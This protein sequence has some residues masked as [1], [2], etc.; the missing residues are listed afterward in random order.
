MVLRCA[1]IGGS[2][3][4]SGPCRVSTWLVTTRLFVSIASG[5]NGLVCWLVGS[6]YCP[7]S[8][9][10]KFLFA[11]SPVEPPQAFVRNDDSEGKSGRGRAGLFCDAPLSAVT[12]SPPT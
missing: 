11:L 5:S 9:G 8:V 4:A 2:A 12:G 10:S 7:K 6:A 3:A 1:G